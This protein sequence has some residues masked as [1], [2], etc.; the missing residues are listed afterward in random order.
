MLIRRFLAR[1]HRCRRIRHTEGRTGIIYLPIRHEDEFQPG[2][3]FRRGV[4]E[5][6]TAAMRYAAENFDNARRFLYWLHNDW[7]ARRRRRCCKMMRCVTPRFGA[8]KVCACRIRQT[9]FAYLP[10]ISGRGRLDVKQ[11]IDL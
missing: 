5:E 1:R 11:T 9:F 6:F 7:D 2:I 4:R 3:Y 10:S 8:I